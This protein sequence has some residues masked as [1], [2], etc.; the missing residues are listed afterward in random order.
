MLDMKTL[1]Q[2][3]RER[4][5]QSRPLGT[6]TSHRGVCAV[7]RPSHTR[8]A[9][10]LRRVSALPDRLSVRSKHKRLCKC[11]CVCGRLSKA[12]LMWFKANITSYEEIPTS[13]FLLARR[14]MED[15]E[16]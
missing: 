10:G 7:T 1:L 11:E 3:M 15:V 4:L 5:V 6:E 16:V 9:S 13:S 8:A 14:L 12:F 2:G